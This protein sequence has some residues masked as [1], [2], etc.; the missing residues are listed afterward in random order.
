MANALL[1]AR[2]PTI[3]AGSESG[4][5]RKSHTGAT[6]YAGPNESLAP[7]RIHTGMLAFGRP[8]CAHQYDAAPAFGCH[9]AVEQV[10]WVGDH[11]RFQ[12]VRR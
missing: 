11:P 5:G 6:V 8:L 3:P 9:G 1:A 4:R 12:D 2:A 10:K 7:P